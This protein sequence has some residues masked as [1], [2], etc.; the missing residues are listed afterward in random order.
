MK[1]KKLRKLME[2]FVDKT[3]K[4]TKDQLLEDKDSKEFFEKFDKAIAD[5]VEIL[6][7]HIST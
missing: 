4:E 1:T 2:K 3:Y 6:K 7:K 5:D